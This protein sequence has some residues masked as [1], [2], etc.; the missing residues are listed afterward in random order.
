MHERSCYFVRNYEE[1][2]SKSFTSYFDI[3]SRYILTILT[4]CALEKTVFV[5]RKLLK[6]FSDVFFTITINKSQG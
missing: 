5:P 1:E 4:R 3:T 2:E 6:Q